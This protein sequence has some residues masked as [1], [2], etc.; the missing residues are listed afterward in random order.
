MVNT[1]TVDP[2]KAKVLT[3]DSRQVIKASGF[4]WAGGQKKK[5]G[6]SKAISVIKKDSIRISVEAE[7]DEPIMNMCLGSA[8]MLSPTL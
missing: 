3:E 4:I 1:Y 7:I 8:L 2:S 5:K 6:L